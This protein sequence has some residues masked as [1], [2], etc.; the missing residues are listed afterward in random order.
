M[1]RRSSGEVVRRGGVR[2]W[3]PRGRLAG[4]QGL[5]RLQVPAPARFGV[6]VC[7]LAGS[8]IGCGV[9]APPPGEPIPVPTLEPPASDGLLDAPELQAVV[10]L[11]VLRDGPGL[12]ALLSDPDP[13]IRARAALALASVQDP[14]SES[15]LAERLRDPEP[16]VRARAA[17]ALG[18]I[19][20]SDGGAALAGALAEEQ[21]PG[22]RARI[23]EAIGKRGGVDAIQALLDTTP[24]DADQPDRTLALTRAG[25]R[26]ARM[27]EL[28]E[29]LAEALRHPDAEVRSAAAYYF[30]RTPDPMAWSVQLPAVRDALESYG[31][32]E[33][34]AMHL[35][36]GLAHRGGITSDPGRV[37]YW[38]RSAEDWRT[39]ANVATALTDPLWVNVSGVRQALVDA[40]DDPSEHV[41]VA[42]AEA[43]SVGFWDAEEELQR[44]IGWV[45]G[46]ADRWRS[47]APFIRLLVEHGFDTVV[48]EWTE[49]MA[50][51]HPSAAH[52]GVEAL[53]EVPDPRATELL[54]S[55]ARHGDPLVRGT[56]LIV[57]AQRWD[58]AQDIEVDE[59]ERRRHFELFVGALEDPEDLPVVRAA[60]ALSHR[61]LH[62]L[63][64]SEALE[65]A[66]RARR[67]T[68]SEAVLT[69]LLGAMNEASVPLL[70]EVL[71]EDP[72]PRLRESA[73]WSL[74]RITGSAVDPGL[75]R[76]AG[77]E[78]TVDW[79][80]L[81]AL[82]PA[83]RMRIETERGVL[84]L[85]LLSEQA[86]LSVLALAEQSREG[87]HDG[88]RFHRVVPNFVV[89]GG[90]FA[91]GDG[92]GGPGYTIGTEITEIPFVRGV[93]GMASLGKDTEGSQYFM[94]HSEQPHMDGGYTPFGWVVEG[95]EVL[96]LLQLGDRILRVTVEPGWEE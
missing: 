43:L 28:F 55:L 9:D 87:L 69:A 12:Q 42:A 72:D 84:V 83:P 23:L 86:P 10:D 50:S 40:L 48:L 44:V 20:L 2:P 45:R 60:Q 38:L 92:N 73:A 6:M 77:P 94:M 8:L 39:R 7:A 27:P 4:G 80:A 61:Q 79:G 63:G 35:A 18:Q 19:P 13:R 11:Q 47:Q 5:L 29:E 71:Q 64:S 90:D 74:E 76:V 31:P 78:R 81:G 59:E 62:P 67:D 3:A 41:R 16:T 17:Y 82:G 93:V 49:R 56:A 33:P 1:A 66:F 70:Q 37:V 75:Y 15:A 32:G 30:A 26:G 14:D 88:T 21:D 22:A 68:G 36:M 58:M 25:I 95:G 52:R 57:Q 96:D 65:R 34:A 54:F 85:R 46:P 24:S 53:L 51:V 89:Q 91:L